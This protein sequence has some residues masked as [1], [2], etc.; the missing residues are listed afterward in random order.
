ML[1]TDRVTVTELQKGQPLPSG[2][3]FFTPYYDDSLELSALTLHLLHM[4]TILSYRHLTSTPIPLAITH[5]YELGY[6]CNCRYATCCGSLK[7][8]LTQRQA[9]AP[10]GIRLLLATAGTAMLPVPV[11]VLAI[12]GEVVLTL[13]EAEGMLTTTVVACKQCLVNQL[14]SMLLT[15][16]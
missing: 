12:L 10:H 16:K 14:R 6:W 4:L 9:A 3:W 11:Q 15:T 13:A 1:Q 7:S 5:S 8:L 2:G